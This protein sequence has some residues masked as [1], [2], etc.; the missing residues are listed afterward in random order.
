MVRIDFN[1]EQLAPVSIGTTPGLAGVCAS[2]KL[3]RRKEGEQ[4]FGQF[5]IGKLALAGF[6][7][8]NIMMLEFPGIP[9]CRRRRRYPPVVVFLPQ[10][11]T[12]GSCD[13]VQRP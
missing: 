4:D 5:L 9:R 11:D 10:P 8:G 1:P 6:A 12:G 2:D 13:A 3:G 7:F